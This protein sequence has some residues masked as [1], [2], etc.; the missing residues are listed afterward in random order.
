MNGTTTVEL[1][2]LDARI[3]EW[4]LPRYHSEMAA[5]ID[6]F[7]CIDEPIA[8]APQSPAQ[9]IPAGI[10]LH[11]ADPNITAI[12]VPRSGLGH[13]K[14]LVTG[15]LVGV[16]DADYTG[17]VLISTWNRSEPGTEPILV[18]PGDRIAQMMFVPVVRPLFDVVDEFTNESTRG[19]GGFGSTGHNVVK[20]G[21]RA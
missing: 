16:I 4:G 3:H 11:I 17:P 15:N 2:I 12:I 5:A 9:L 1:R 18:H 14:G 6:L 21:G 19:D 13:R 20:I 8:I 7:A 10:S